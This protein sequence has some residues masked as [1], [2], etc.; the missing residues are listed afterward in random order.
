MSRLTRELLPGIGWPA[1]WLYQYAKTNGLKPRVT[2]VYRSHRQQ[3]WLRQ[4]YERGLS[5]LYAAPAGQSYHQYN[6]AFDMVTEDPALVGGIWQ[7]MGGSW[8]PSDPVHF[9]A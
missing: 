6:R 9:Q 5:E 3:A 8:W 1:E 7:Q 4:R 2:S